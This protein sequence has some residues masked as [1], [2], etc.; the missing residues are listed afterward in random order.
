[1]FDYL[2]W[3]NDCLEISYIL[4]YWWILWHEFLDDY[5]IIYIERMIFEKFDT[6]FIIDEVYDMKET[7][8]NKM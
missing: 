1:L 8:L 5:L 3:E 7:Q 6:Y 2:H 4:Y